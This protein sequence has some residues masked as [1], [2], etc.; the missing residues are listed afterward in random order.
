MGKKTRKCL[1]C[2]AQYSGKTCGCRTIFNPYARPSCSACI[3]R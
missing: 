1:Y 3:R 2:G